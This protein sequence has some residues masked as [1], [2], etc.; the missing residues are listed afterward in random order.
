M[1]H[2]NE[3]GQ[4]FNSKSIRSML[5]QRVAKVERWTAAQVARLV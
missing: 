5:A 4:P 2:L 1:G 3:R